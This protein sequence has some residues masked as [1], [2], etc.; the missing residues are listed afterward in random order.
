MKGW[1]VGLWLVVCNWSAHGQPLTRERLT[2]TWIGVHYAW[3]SD[4]FVPTG[5]YLRFDTDSSYTIGALNEQ[6]PPIRKKWSLTGGA[7]RLD[8][9]QF[10]AGAVRVDGDRLRIDGYFTLTFRRF[11]DVPVSIDS[12]RRVLTNRVWQIG[13]QRLHLHDNGQACRETSAPES[14]ISGDRTIHRW[15]LAQHR[16]SVF[17]LVKGVQGDSMGNYEPTRQILAFGNNQIRAVGWD[18]DEQAV[19]TQTLRPLTVTLSP[20]QVCEPVGFQPCRTYLYQP[21]SQYYS[22]D[23]RGHQERLYFIRKAFG[24]YKPPSV[25]GQSG[26]LRVR[27]QVNCRGEAGRFELLELDEAYQKRPFDERIS[28]QILAICRRSLST[29]WLPGKDGQDTTPSD[30]VQFITLR[31]KDGAITE[32]FP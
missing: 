22:F 30:Y 25:T 11:Q 31:L 14:L 24:A 7:A 29:G 10:K 19:T 3:D 5:S 17:L 2:G 27:F 26:L 13:G 20:G 8:T 12:V 18:E 6:E 28:R 21:L 15:S 9:S 4:F 16:N 23:Q 1:W 32:I